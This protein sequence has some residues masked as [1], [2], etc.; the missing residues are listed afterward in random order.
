MRPGGPLVLQCIALDGQC[1][2]LWGDTST[3]WRCVDP[4]KQTA[5]EC[6]LCASEARTREQH[7]RPRSSV[8]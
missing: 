4:D 1:Q 5:A 2:V 6:D 8:G 3:A 7:G